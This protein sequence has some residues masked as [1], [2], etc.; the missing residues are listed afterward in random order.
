MRGEHSQRNYAFSR[1]PLVLFLELLYDILHQRCKAL[2]SPPFSVVRS[3]YLTARP[4][5]PTRRRP[6]GKE[7]MMSKLIIFALSFMLAGCGASMSAVGVV[8][9][10]R[11]YV[12]KHGDFLSS[13]RMILVVDE[14]GKVVASSGGTVQG[15][16]AF[17]TQAAI[18]IVSAG[19]TVYGFQALSQASLR[20]VNQDSKNHQMTSSNCGEIATPLLTPGTDA[21][22]ELGAGPKVCNFSDSLN[23]SAAAFQ[24]T[25]SVLA[26]GNGY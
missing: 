2:V 6:E 5:R 7:V 24:G 10:N 11:V 14:N 25:V 1:V 17:T 26:P 20:F 21:T 4:S 12:I 8:E 22:V 3:N 23:P 13:S 18:G 9:K 15:G 19:A 16:G